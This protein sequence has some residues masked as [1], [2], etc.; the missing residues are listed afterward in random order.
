MIDRER[1]RPLFSDLYSNTEGKG[2][3]LSFGCLEERGHVF[4]GML[5]EWIKPFEGNPFGLFEEI[6]K[7]AYPK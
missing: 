1:F 5:D 7:T 3:L 2:G 6:R 4:F